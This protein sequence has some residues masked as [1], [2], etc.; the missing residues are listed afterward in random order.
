VSFALRASARTLRDASS[1]REERARERGWRIDDA[2]AVTPCVGL[3]DSRDVGR[4]SPEILDAARIA[5]AI[6][7]ESI[8]IGKPSKST[9]SPSISASSFRV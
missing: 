9:H 6:A 7:P 4:L 3:G 2:P 1:R 5:C 8:G